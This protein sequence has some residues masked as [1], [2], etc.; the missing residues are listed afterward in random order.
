MARGFGRSFAWFQIGCSFHSV[1]QP[2]WEPDRESSGRGKKLEMMPGSEGGDATIQRK[3]IQAG[4][5]GRAQGR[6]AAVLDPIHLACLSLTP[7]TQ[8]VKAGLL[9]LA[10]ES[11]PL[12]DFCSSMKGTQHLPGH[13]SVAGSSNSPATPVPSM[14]LLSHPPGL[15]K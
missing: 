9:V 2:P 15:H 4:L 7:H 1:I 11:A 5:A 3:E 10:P 13:P 14:L 8:Q 6:W 12:P